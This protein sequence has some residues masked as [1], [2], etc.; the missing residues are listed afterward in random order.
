MVLQEVASV[1]PS[2]TPLRRPLSQEPIFVPDLL[3][4][5]PMRRID[6]EHTKLAI[7]LAFAAGVSG[8][9]FS[10]ALDRATIAP[11]TWEPASANTSEPCTAM[12]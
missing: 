7:A 11:S 1:L 5:T 6:V 9:V 4:A 3:H 8:G 12:T 2:Q 10:E